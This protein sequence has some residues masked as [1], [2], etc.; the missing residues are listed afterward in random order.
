MAEFIHALN[1]LPSGST[2]DFADISV[3]LV[4]YFDSQ[5]QLFIPEPYNPDLVTAD[6]PNYFSDLS[7]NIGSHTLMS[8][9]LS[10][11]QSIWENPSERSAREDPSPL[12]SNDSMSDVSDEVS[13]AEAGTEMAEADIPIGGRGVENTTEAVSPLRRLLT[14]VGVYLPLSPKTGRDIDEFYWRADINTLGIEEEDRRCS[15]CRDL[16]TDRSSKNPSTSAAS[17]NETLSGSAQQTNE[18]PVQLPAC[19]HILG[20]KC[21]RQWI[22]LAGSSPATCPYCR[23]TLESRYPSYWDTLSTFADMLR[24]FATVAT[25]W[26]ATNPPVESHDAFTAWASENWTDQMARRAALRAIERFDVLCLG[27]VSAGVLF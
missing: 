26:L 19:N 6:G 7:P 24:D 22:Q 3:D 13:N 16:Y 11:Q 18:D 15:I 23:T 14:T 21:L 20:E 17:M 25:A 1:T 27:L 5:S 10:L 8:E 4:S 12:H 9:N 2:D